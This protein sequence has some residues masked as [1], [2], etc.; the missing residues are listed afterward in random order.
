MAIISE[1]HL[2]TWKLKLSTMKTVL[3][4][5][6]L[7]NQEA[8]H[9]LKVNHNNEILCFCSELKCFGVTLDRSLMY[10]QQLESL[11]KKLTLCVALLR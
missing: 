7:N 9:E 3:T 11:R 5:F 8:E 1:L 10:H 6:H 4:V 2:Q